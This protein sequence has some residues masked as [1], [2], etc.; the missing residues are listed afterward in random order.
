M[1]MQPLY[2]FSRFALPNDPSKLSG[3]TTSKFALLP[4][5]SLEC[6]L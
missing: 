4:L 2:I 3:R 5:A 6:T 1:Q